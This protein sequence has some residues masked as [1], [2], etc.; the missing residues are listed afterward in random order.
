MY[1]YGGRVSVQ[2]QGTGTETRPHAFD[3]KTASF[4][5]AVRDVVSSY[6]EFALFVLPDE[7]VSIEATGGPA[8]TYTLKTD[9][10]VAEQ[11][12]QR[13]WRWT[14]PSTPGIYPLKFS[15]PAP[16]DDAITLRAIVLVPFAEVKN[17]SLNGYRI[18]DYPPPLKGNPVYLSPRGF[19]EVTK[20]NQ[21][22]KLSPHFELKQFICKED[23]SKT[24]PKYLIVQ[25]R[26]L[27]KLEAILADVNE[28]LGVKVDTL[29]LMSA[30]RTP[31]YNHAIGDVKYSMHQFGS[32]ADIYIDPEKKDRMADLNH[33][34]VI[35]MS[36][37]KFLYDHIETWL[38][39]KPFANLQGG[40]GFYPATNAHPPFVHV[41][42]RGT[43]ARWRG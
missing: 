3:A 7:K 10:G 21:D 42:V 31:F 8:A 16:P 36:D 33:D 19:V 22:T 38:T 24:Y 4:A 9:A 30:Y 25:E 28:D 39:T 2:V 35:D 23:T 14:A 15:V 11:I 32:A 12:G 40:M 43:K 5:I 1:L 41:D 13:K 17:G 6:R 18:G 37:S 20:E 27:L 29:H 34:R 26:L